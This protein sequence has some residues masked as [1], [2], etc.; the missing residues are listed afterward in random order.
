MKT[1]EEAS[2]DKAEKKIENGEMQSEKWG[3]ARS[4]NQKR[5]VG[6]ASIGKWNKTSRRK[7]TSNNGQTTAEEAKRLVDLEGGA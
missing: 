1:V 3:N 4:R 2:K 5:N 7:F 6:A